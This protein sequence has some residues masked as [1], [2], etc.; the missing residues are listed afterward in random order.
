MEPSLKDNILMVK[1]TVLVNLNGVTEVI[2]KEN[3]EI[4]ILRVKENMSGGKNKFF[5]ENHILVKL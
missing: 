5:S 4:I 3:L 1:N 2:T